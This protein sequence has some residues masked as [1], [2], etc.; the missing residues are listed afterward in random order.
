MCCRISVARAAISAHVN[1]P[2]NPAIFRSYNGSFTNACNDDNGRMLLIDGLDTGTDA[3]DDGNDDGTLIDDNG[4][5]CMVVDD[6]M[7]AS[8]RIGVDDDAVGLLT[9]FLD[10]GDSVASIE[11]LLPLLLPVADVIVVIAAGV[12]VADAVLPVVMVTV[13]VIMDLSAAAVA[14]ANKNAT[15]GEV[16]HRC[17]C[18]RV[19]TI[20]VRYRRLV[21]RVMLYINPNNNINGIQATVTFR[22]TAIACSG[23]RPP[24]NGGS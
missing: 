12:G 2:I 11:S 16:C 10:R 20:L 22:Y 7:M 19:V 8:T 9:L 23:L 6:G 3:T 5:I 15:N 17:L 1:S 14:R 4:T 18:M 21:H 24:A 13:F